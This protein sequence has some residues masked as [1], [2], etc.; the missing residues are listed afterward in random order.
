M[1]QSLVAIL[2]VVFLLSG[3]ISEAHA[4][5]YAGY[6]Y[7]DVTQPI[8]PQSVTPYYQLEV[9]HYQLYV[10]YHRSYTAY[11]FYPP[12]G[13]CC[14]VTGY[15]FLGYPSFIAPPPAVVFTPR[16]IIRR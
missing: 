3:G 10:P 11:P 2:W 13:A 4:Q 7:P 1:K 5:Y 8:P 14:A 16:V 6:P 12:Y 9:M 15:P